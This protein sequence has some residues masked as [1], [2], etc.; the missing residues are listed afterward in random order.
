MK[1][2]V[3]HANKLHPTGG[4]SRCSFRRRS[5]GGKVPLAYLSPNKRSVHRRRSAPATR[6]TP[7][8]VQK[9]KKK[10]GKA[11]CWIAVGF[12][13]DPGVKCKQAS[14]SVQKNKRSS[15]ANFETARPWARVVG[16][17]VAQV[18]ARR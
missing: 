1:Q 14:Q 17:S 5:E 15:F 2:P 13:K 4:T 3:I 10:K 9:K 6:V 7:D 8:S 12:F 16:D 18:T 11:N